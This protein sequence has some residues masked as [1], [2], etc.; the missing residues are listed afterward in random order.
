ML[1]STVLYS[2]FELRT[3]FGQRLFAHF[4]Q[5]ISVCRG[6]FAQ[7]EQNVCHYRRLFAQ[8]EKRAFEILIANFEMRI[9]YRA[10]TRHGGARYCTLILS[11]G[12]CL[13]GDCLLILS[14]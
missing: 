14:K 1:P 4:E 6:L 8:N 10:R 11:C 13:V 5:I 9:Q 12:P 2:H 7:N 3:L